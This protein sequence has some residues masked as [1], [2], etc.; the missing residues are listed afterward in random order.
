MRWLGWVEVPSANH[1]W[2]ELRNNDNQTVSVEGWTLGD[3]S[4]LEILLAGTI[5]SNAYAV[6]E[7]SS[8]ESASGPAFLIYTGALV[9]TGATLTLRS[10]TGVIMDQVAGGE[11]WQEIGG[12][13]ATKE[14]AQ[15]T[16]QGWVTAVATPGAQNT[17]AAPSN[18]SGS[19]TSTSSSQT[20]ESSPSTSSGT[21]SKSIGAK[22]TVRLGSVNPIL[23]LTVDQQDIAYVNQTTSFKVTPS[24][25]GDTIAGSLV[26]AWNFGDSF[27]A[28]GT[29]VSH[30]YPYPG[31]Y[32]VTVRACLCQA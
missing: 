18:P 2:I 13:N 10:D 7:R 29:T 3:G 4:N 30:H 23:K 11:N 21:K 22:S 9:N 25:V 15:Y 14:T 19:S 32:V 5:V 6:L 20:T 12:D 16:S 26:Y 1:E 31:T 24:G 27:T 28:T 17:S 8:E